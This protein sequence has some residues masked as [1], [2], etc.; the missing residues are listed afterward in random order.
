MRPPAKGFGQLQSVAASSWCQLLPGGFGN[1]RPHQPPSGGLGGRRGAALVA[2][3]RVVLDGVRQCLA[4]LVI[5]F[6]GMG[7]LLWMVTIK[8]LSGAFAV[9][10]V[11]V[12]AIYAIAEVL[13]LAD[14]Q[15]YDLTSNRV[16]GHSLKHLVASFAAWP[17]VT[18]LWSPLD[19]SRKQGRIHSMNSDCS[20]AQ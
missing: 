19:G 7:L 15:I 20:S 11:A 13:E 12:V 17:V 4:W 14:H 3:Q 5:Q 2:A 8:P 9:R 18:V 6:G 1:C 10:W 16:S